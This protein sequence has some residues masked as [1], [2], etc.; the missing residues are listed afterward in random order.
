M[1]PGE[2]ILNGVSSETLGF[3]VQYRPDIPSPR[4]KL[5]FVDAPGM[6]GSIVYDDNEFEDVVF[7]LSLIIK[8]K[9]ADNHSEIMDK[10]WDVYDYFDTGK[11]VRMV[12]WWDDRK[13]YLVIPEEGKG[14]VFKN[15]VHMEGNIVATINLK[16]RPYKYYNGY[17]LVKHPSNTI[18]LESPK[19]T[20]GG[21]PLILIEGSG[22]L[23]LTINKKVF[24]VGDIPEN[25]YIDSELRMCYSKNSSG[26]VGLNS[27]VLSKEYPVLTKGTNTIT[28]K[29]TNIQSVSIQ[30][31]WRTR[32]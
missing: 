31:R 30:P 4:R 7:E 28:V 18:T 17:P 27:F 1:Q 3:R 16:C 22:A 26:Y 15:N 23:E 20:H 13:E 21:L 24:K 8:G 12:P 10:I 32:I 19:R 9:G 5:E 25:V 11:Y 29:G 14:P 6:S 2:I